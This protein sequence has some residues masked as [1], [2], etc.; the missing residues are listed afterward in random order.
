MTILELEDKI[1]QLF[2]VENIGNCA[3]RFLGTTK[4]VANGSEE[5]YREMLITRLR[6]GGLKV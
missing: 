2:E 6:Q 3:D 4:Y 1:R 5:T